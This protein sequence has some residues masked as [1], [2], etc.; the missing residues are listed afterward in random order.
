MRFLTPSE[1][2]RLVLAIDPR[3]RLLVLVGAYGGLRPGELFALRRERVDPLR[4]RLEVLDTAVEV[5][6]HH[7]VGPPKTRAGRRAV[8]LPRFAADELGAA[9]EG[10][11]ASWLLFPA[12]RGGHVRASASRRRTWGPAVRAAGLEPLRLH[13]LRHTAVAFWIAAGASP[14]LIE[15]R[16]GHT[17]VVTVLDRY[18]HLL[19]SEEDRVTG[20]LHAMA[21]AAQDEVGDA[22]VVPLRGVHAR[23]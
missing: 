5:R 14:T 10:V 21:R 17:S 8:P 20:A 13:D 9:L 15:G 2:A 4:G 16:A 23:R 11:P 12:P 18:G 7:Q 22:D 6:G 1:V 19:P 3:Y